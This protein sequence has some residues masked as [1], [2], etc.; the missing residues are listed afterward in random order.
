M[1]RFPAGG[2]NIRRARHSSRVGTGPPNMTLCRIDDLVGD[3]VDVFPVPPIGK[4]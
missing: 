1:R 4:S 2:F 3:R